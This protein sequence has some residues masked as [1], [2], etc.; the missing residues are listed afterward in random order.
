MSDQRWANPLTDADIGEIIRS[1]GLA[2]VVTLREDA[3]AEQIVDC[4]AGNRV[5]EK[6]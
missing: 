5:Y 2:A 3:T 6:A 4:L 1:F